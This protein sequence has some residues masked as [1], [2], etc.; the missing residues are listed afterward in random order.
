LGEQLK[1][2]EQSP[3]NMTARKEAWRAAMRLGLFE[4]AASLGAELDPAERAAM[5]G[6]RI[7]LAIRY[8]RIDAASLTGAARYERLD[9]ALAVTD[10]LSKDF[11]AGQVIDTE[12]RRRLYD[13]V[14][15][16]VARQRAAD[17]VT[18]FEALQARGGDAPSWAIS[19][20]PPSGGSGASI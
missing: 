7:A 6:D 17:A 19:R 9:A 20:D 14:S 18:L 5:E 10:A 2:L 8:G 3:N 13:R 15:A 12:Q 4:Q 11:L 1:V 16:L